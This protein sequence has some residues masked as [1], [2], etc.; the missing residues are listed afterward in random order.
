MQLIHSL[1]DVVEIVPPRRLLLRGNGQPQNSVSI[2]LKTRALRID[3]GDLL[4]NRNL[5]D[6][7]VSISL[8][9]ALI[10]LPRKLFFRP[11]RRCRSVFHLALAGI[12]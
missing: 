3:G 8:R 5:L 2:C 10:P 1:S 4:L 6:R 11:L 7:L 9:H 12:A